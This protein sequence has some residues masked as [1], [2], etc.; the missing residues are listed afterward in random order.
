MNK[1]FSWRKGVAATAALT[2]MGGLLA[3]CG[4]NNGNGNASPSASPAAGASGSQ[5][6][7]AAPAEQVELSLLINHTWYPVNQWVGPIAEEITKR[8]GVKLKVTVATDDKQLPLAIASG[9]MPDLVFASSELDRLSNPNISYSWDELIAKYAPDFKIDPTRI[10]INTVDDG[11]FYTVRNAF[12]T[13]E[14]W[15]S[16]KYALGNDGNP[17][18]AVREDLLQELGNPKI[19]TLQDFVALLEAVKSKYPDMIPLVLDINWSEQYF[20]G[21]FGATPPNLWHEQDGQVQL[22]IS[23][24]RVLETYRFMNELYRKGLI[25]AENFAYA[26]DQIDD[27]YATSGKAFAHMHTVSIADRDNLAL[28]KTSETFRFKQLPSK[29]SPD[30]VRVNDGVGFS[31]IFITK[32]NKH[33]EASIKLMQFLASEEGK[34]LTMFGIEGEHW[35][36]NDEGYPNLKYNPSDTDF[37]TKN[38]IKWWYL[39]SDAIVEGLWGYVPGT[40][41]T[42]AL[43]ETKEITQ[44]K[45]E[46]GLIQ[47]KADS[48]ERTIKTKIEELVKNE[49]VKVILSDSPEQV[50][51]NYNAMI[52]NAKKIGLDK[53]NAWANEEYAKKKELFK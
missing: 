41:T 49:R 53:L 5:G 12:A 15:A 19:E 22:G 45:P 39:Y 47:V 48:A 25:Q 36:W 28:E 8:T 31:G 37:V 9:D 4:G 3:A 6:S 1:R 38:G 51:K 13:Q 7:S 27:Q 23:D 24:P 2:L 17:G 21:Q 10:A 18:I 40:Q 29:L 14:E 42:Q 50:E 33:P 11:H 46:L 20:L 16:S 52:D 30:A 26:N 32:K 43:I 35:T 34:R 44:Y